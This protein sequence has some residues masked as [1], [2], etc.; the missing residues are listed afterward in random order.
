[1]RYFFVVDGSNTTF[2]VKPY[3]KEEDAVVYRSMKKS[4]WKKVAKLGTF[5]EKSGK[6]ELGTVIFFII[7]IITRYFK[8]EF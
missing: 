4:A 2:I 5:Y 6:R 7:I 8:M 1:M 3:V